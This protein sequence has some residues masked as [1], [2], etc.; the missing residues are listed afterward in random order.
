MS[1]TVW[2]AIAVATGLLLIAILM[3]CLCLYMRSRQHACRTRHHQAIVRG[4][5]GKWDDHMVY[6]GMT[7]PQSGHVGAPPAYADLNHKDTA[8]MLKAERV[9]PVPLD[10]HIG[11]PPPP[12]S[13]HAWT[14]EFKECLFT[15]LTW[16]DAVNQAQC[17]TTLHSF[18][19]IE[20]LLP[21]LSFFTNEEQPGGVAL[22]VIFW[23]VILD[24]MAVLLGLA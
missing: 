7:A 22:A 11:T 21:T 18:N 13:S 4:Q 17:G 2:L 10:A 12:Y 3:V 23:V 9:K 14:K 6:H 16:T 20:P 19:L 8:P 15:P 24:F 1:F 5:L